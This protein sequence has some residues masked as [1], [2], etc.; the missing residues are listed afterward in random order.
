DGH[1][2]YDVHRARSEG[3][4]RREVGPAGVARA[5]PACAGAACGA[6]AG[7]GGA[8]AGNACGADIAPGPDLGPCA[9]NVIPVV[10]FI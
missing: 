10:P 4:T 9:V 1:P 6:A 2:R 8:C 5:G 7:V 3:G